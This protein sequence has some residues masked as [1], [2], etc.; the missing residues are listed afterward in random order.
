VRNPPAP[1]RCWSLFAG[2]TRTCL[3]F[4]FT[5]ILSV[6]V[7]LFALVG[8]IWPVGA[9]NETCWLQG[10]AMLIIGLWVKPPM[11]WVERRQSSDVNSESVNMYGVGV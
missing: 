8:V 3:W 2:C 9:A 4:S 11:D 7:I 5:A 1:H 10:L 6:I